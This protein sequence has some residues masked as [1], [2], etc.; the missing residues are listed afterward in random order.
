[1][2]DDAAVRAQ[3]YK[4]HQSAAEVLLSKLRQRFD[5][6]S[7]GNTVCPCCRCPAPPRPAPSRPATVYRC[8]KPPWLVVGLQW[9]FIYIHACT[10]MLCIYVCE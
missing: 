2:V 9:V 4:E 8:F 3:E 7:S 10:C 6:Q 5:K 1:M